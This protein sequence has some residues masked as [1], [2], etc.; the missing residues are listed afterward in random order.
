MQAK[1]PQFVPAVFSPTNPELLSYASLADSASLALNLDQSAYRSSDFDFD[2]RHSDLYNSSRKAES[3]T[4]A[5]IEGNLAPAVQNSFTSL[6]LASSASPLSDNDPPGS[7][8]SFAI[9][10]SFANNVQSYQANAQNQLQFLDQAFPERAL[11]LGGQGAINL[12]LSNEA[13][14]NETVVSN[15]LQSNNTARSN[16]IGQFDRNYAEYLREFARPHTLS[17]PMRTLDGIWT[18]YEEGGTYG[19]YAGVVCA[20]LGAVDGTFDLPL[21]KY[22]FNTARDTEFSSRQ[23]GANP[24]VSIYSES[25]SG[26]FAAPV[27][28]YSGATNGYVPTGP[29]GVSGPTGPTGRNA[30]TGG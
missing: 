6:A 14:Y 12:A 18:G 11:G 8:G 24:N 15:N 3:D 20:I 28:T 23:Y 22:R 7:I 27:T 17:T 19:I 10:R 30:P 26:D 5:A 21:Y 1:L 2:T 13:I 25:L 29:N 16:A 4:L 9:A